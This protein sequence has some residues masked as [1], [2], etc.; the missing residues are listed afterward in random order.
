MGCAASTPSAS[1]S[2]SAS[3][4]APPQVLQTTATSSSGGSAPASLSA[5]PPAAPAAL[6]TPANQATSPVSTQGIHATSPVSTQGAQATPPD[7]PQAAHATSPVS[8][9]EAQVREVLF[10]GQVTHGGKSCAL[11]QTIA[12]FDA[13]SCSL[14][15]TDIHCEAVLPEGNASVRSS[16]WKPSEEADPTFHQ[17][18]A[19]QLLKLNWDAITGSLSAVSAATSKAGGRTDISAPTSATMN[20][21]LADGSATTVAKVT[22]D[23][24]DISATTVAK[25]TDDGADTSATT[26]TTITYDR[27]GAISWSGSVSFPTGDDLSTCGI[28]LLSSPSGFELELHPL[29]F[30]YHFAVGGHPTESIGLRDRLTTQLCS[31]CKP[32]RRFR[33]LLTATGDSIDSGSGSRGSGAGIESAANYILILSPHVWEAPTVAQEVQA[34]EKLGKII[35]L[36]YRPNEAVHTPATQPTPSSPD[37]AVLAIAGLDLAPVIASAPPGLATLFDFMEAIPYRA[38]PHMEAATLRHMAQLTGWGAMLQSLLEIQDR[39]AQEVA[40]YLKLLEASKD[41]SVWYG[42]D[43]SM[44]SGRDGMDS[45]GIL[46]YYEGV[47]FKAA[48]EGSS[49]QQLRG[50]YQAT[51]RSCLPPAMAGNT[52]NAGNAGISCN[53]GDAG[54][55]GTGGASLQKPDEGE[56]AEAV[57]PE[58]P[59]T[60]AADE[61]CMR[62]DTAGLDEDNQDAGTPAA[63][64]ACM[65]T[66]EL[67]ISYEPKINESMPAYKHT[68]MMAWTPG[69]VH[70]HQT[71]ESLEG[72]YWATW[73]GQMLPYN[74]DSIT[75]G[76]L[77]EAEQQ[78]KQQEK[79]QEQQ[80]QQQDHQDGRDASSSTIPAAL[81]FKE[82]DD[83]IILKPMPFLWHFY[84]LGA[85]DCGALAG[86]LAS[87]LIEVAAPGRK[88]RVYI[89]CG[90]LSHSNGEETHPVNRPRPSHAL[91]HASSG[92]FGCSSSSASGKAGEFGYIPSVPAVN[93]FV[94]A[95]QQK[96]SDVKELAIMK[97]GRWLY[98]EG[99]AVQ[100]VGKKAGLVWGW[101]QIDCQFKPDVIKKDQ[102]PTGAVVGKK[103][104]LVWGWYQIDCQFKPDVIKKVVGKNAGL[105]WGWYQIDCQFKPDVIKKD[106]GLIELS[107]RFE[108]KHAGS[109]PSYD[110]I[111]TLNWD[112]ISGA[113][114]LREPNPR[115]TGQLK[116]GQGGIFHIQ[117]NY[118][119]ELTFKP[120]PFIWHYFLSHIQRESSDMEQLSING[121]RVRCWYDNIASAVINKDAMALGVQY[122]QN[123]VLILSP[124]VFKSPYVKFEMMSAL[125]QGKRVL[126][127][128]D[129]TPGLSSSVDLASIFE[130]AP[131]ELRVLITKTD[132]LGDTGGLDAAPQVV[133][134]PFVASSVGDELH[135]HTK[136]V[137]ST[138][139][140][141]ELFCDD[142]V[143]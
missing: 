24:A 109:I 8:T 105:V 64:A 122:S 18:L 22:D 16:V 128:Y 74:A 91:T 94:E 111:F 138:S 11:L 96:K 81:H 30:R 44:S 3:A 68:A 6:P 31:M 102:R 66:L 86:I 63:I 34:A 27:A 141:G 42:E 29:P 49:E 93:V 40:P 137:L 20:G 140:F 37:P 35:L 55:A 116:G 84:V 56:E 121:R 129:P 95:M 39:S 70:I 80:Q 83:D 47:V 61:P 101:Y 23:G 58:A 134:M 19:N 119:S 90:A 7:S 28:L 77:T 52:G 142:K 108:S 26:A 21:G 46:R 4:V 38:H 107:F 130:G 132:T 36:L 136:Q 41:L 115:W 12:V 67:D 99:V 2:T 82:H 123:F 9:Q 87:T 103:A 120:Q 117:N 89:A 76:D 53:A 32:G 59:A 133:V 50:W 143:A 73:T 33:F 17:A 25:V 131:E 57:T 78:Q 139:G 127:L 1:A 135:L 72:R 14:T 75:A 112:Q 62:S 71:S 13:A 48:K 125:G 69:S 100:V 118:G 113:V 92:S 45:S 43:R 51:V 65:G 85:P 110:A 5:A 60:E 79:Q 98:Y 126:L 54:N 104:G 88:P 10:E 114:V 15:L 97:D 106:Q 124:S